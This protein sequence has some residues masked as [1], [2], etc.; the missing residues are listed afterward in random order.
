MKPFDVTIAFRKNIGR[1]GAPPV[2][3][4]CERVERVFALNNHDALHF[5]EVRSS[6][7]AIACK[8]LWDR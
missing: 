7:R 8:C 3:A 1:R 6:G 5:A 4:K 2:W